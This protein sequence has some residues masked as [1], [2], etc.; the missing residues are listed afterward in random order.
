LLFRTTK[1][2]TKRYLNS[3]NVKIVQSLSGIGFQ[4]RLIVYKVDR[5]LS[6]RLFG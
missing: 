6:V 5:Q 1:V 3:W 2:K 4:T